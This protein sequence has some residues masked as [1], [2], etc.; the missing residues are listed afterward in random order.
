MSVFHGGATIGVPDAVRTGCADCGSRAPVL[1]ALWAA[2]GSEPRVAGLCD[3]QRDG[4]SRWDLVKDVFKIDACVWRSC[5]GGFLPVADDADAAISHH[6][7]A[8]EGVGKLERA[9]AR[10]VVGLALFVEA[11]GT[12]VRVPAE[13]QGHD[14]WELTQQ[15]QDFLEVPEESPART[16]RSRVRVEDDV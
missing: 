7:T 15:R 3:C 9:V 11:S 10:E 13:H 2:A 4:K 1:P 8:P 5:P 6:V 16:I 14:A 12:G